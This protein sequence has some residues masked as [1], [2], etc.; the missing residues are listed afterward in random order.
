[1]KK[2]G[3]LFGRYIL[4]DKI[5]R[6]GMGEIFRSTSHG[7]EGFRK[8]VVIK[9]IL[10]HLGEDRRFVR[11]FINEAKLSARLAHSKVVQIY[12][13]GSLNGCLYI[14]MEY[15]D[16]PDL[17]KTLRR[18]H[19]LDRAVPV[20]VAAYTIS[21]VCQGLHYAHTLTDVSGKSLSIVHRDISP[22]NILLSWNGDV[23]VADFGIAKAANIVEKTR[24]GVRKGKL[25]YMA[26]EHL[27]GRVEQRSDI[28]AAGVVLWELLA[29]QPLFK[30]MN[31]SIIMKSI[32]SGD[33][34]RAGDCVNLPTEMAT[35]LDRA[36]ALSPQDRFQTADEMADAL[37]TF[38]HRSGRKA[39]ARELSAFL[40]QLFQEAPGSSI[41]P[42][43]GDIKISGHITRLGAEPRKAHK[44]G[45]LSRGIE[46]ENEKDRQK[47]VIIFPEIVGPEIFTFPLFCW[48]GAHLSASN[49]QL[50]NKLKGG[51]NVYLATKESEFDLE[52]RGSEEGASEANVRT[53][54]IAVKQDMVE[55]LVAAA[56][57]VVERT[58]DG[59]GG[60]AIATRELRTGGVSSPGQA[61]ADAPLIDSAEEFQP[62]ME[63][64][65]RIVSSATAAVQMGYLE[66]RS[67]RTA[68]VYID[69]IKTDLNTPL[70]GK[71]KLILVTGPH[72]ISLTVS[73]K[74]HDVDVLIKP[75]VTS[76][77]NLKINKDS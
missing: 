20:E 71:N 33:I 60:D 26:P 61:E 70:V 64:E 38:I 3:E 15:V 54:K 77:L 35:I 45:H 14:S 11:M 42:P 72:K 25:G 40:N 73:G 51:G 57:G 22:S 31:D 49:L 55:T 6:G 36:L 48:K 59:V 41:L 44:G 62:A 37:T 2:D 65:P 47:V 13:L 9:K 10:E 67:V 68:S 66:V 56:G 21:C 18:A 28:Y 23:K 58:T 34:P 17:G 29:G 19:K 76:R 69:G 46:L 4:H 16:G 39:G 52:H 75:K 12:E 50:N 32:A 27:E 5:G 43:Q 24:T 1:M 7:V 74:R 53:A 8:Q 30:G 63:D